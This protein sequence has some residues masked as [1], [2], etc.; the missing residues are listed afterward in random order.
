VP[1]QK[2][3]LPIVASFLKK[4]LFT[5]QFVGFLCFTQRGE[6]N[7][8]LG[9]SKIKN[10]H[11][12][13]RKE[14]ESKMKCKVFAATT[15]SSRNMRQMEMEREECSEQQVQLDVKYCVCRFF[16]SFLFSL[17]SFLY[18]SSFG[19]GDDD[20]NKHLQFTLWNSRMWRDVEDKD[21]GIYLS[22]T[23]ST[24]RRERSIFRALFFC[25]YEGEKKNFNEVFSLS[26]KYLNAGHMSHG[27]TLHRARHRAT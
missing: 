2:R 27:L 20:N 13:K 10:T 12:E 9:N 11:K 6:K 19:S 4:K 15:R 24:R 5:H 23:R 18:L 21:D 8:R 7:T 26:F 14:R 22:R 25:I 16:F 3:D 1:E 17:F